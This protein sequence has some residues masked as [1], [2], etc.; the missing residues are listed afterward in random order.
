MKK[1]GVIYKITNI[2]DEKVYIG[3]TVLDPPE[4]RIEYHFKPSS[5]NVVSRAIKKHGVDCFVS[6][7]ILE[8]FDFKYMD[9]MEVYFI[10]LFNCIVPE[11]YNLES[12]GYNLRKPHKHTILKNK[13]R[14]KQRVRIHGSPMKGVPKS[15]SHKKTMSESRK[16]F[17]TRNR[18]RSRDH[19][20]LRRKARGDFVRL[21]AIKI[22]TKEEY[23]YD[24]IADCARDLNLIQS[25]VS[26]VLK[27]IQ[28]RTQHKGYRFEYL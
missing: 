10:Q 22:E 5:N 6:E 18:K 20:I 1:V 8:C 12:G 19:T 27:K 7:V 13:L 16:G 3:Q 26:A 28:G 21:K 15:E 25:C 11:G 24:S 23:V 9:E 4:K 2:I 14:N 17:D